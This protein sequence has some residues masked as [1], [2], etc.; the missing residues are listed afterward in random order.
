MSMHTLR[1]SI[2]FTVLALLLTS[3]RAEGFHDQLISEAK[4]SAPGEVQLHIINSKG[5]LSNFIGKVR[6]AKKIPGGNVFE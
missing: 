1:I 2:L 6:S 3:A 4:Q 5:R